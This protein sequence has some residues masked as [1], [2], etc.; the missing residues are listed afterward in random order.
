MKRLRPNKSLCDIGEALLLA[1]Q[2][3][4]SGALVPIGAGA[5]HELGKRLIRVAKGVED[6]RVTFEQKKNGRPSQSERDWHIASIY[7]EARARRANHRQAIKAV[8]DASPALRLADNGIQKVAQKLM[9]A[10]IVSDD[11]ARAGEEP[12]GVA[13]AL[14]FAGPELNIPALRAKVA[15]KAHRGS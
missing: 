10:M 5:L 13:C 1:Y 15:K 8:R 9:A 7:W 12:D 4:M 14:D 11:T 6:A 2:T 3:P